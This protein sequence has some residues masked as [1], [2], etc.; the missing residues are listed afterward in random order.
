MESYENV[1]KRCKLF[2]KE[3][4][5]NSKFDTIVI[6]THNTNATC[7]E[8]ILKNITPNFKDSKFMNVYC[9]GEIKLINY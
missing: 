9:N 5:I 1:Y 3:N 7:I 8:Y 6:V 4:I 2:V